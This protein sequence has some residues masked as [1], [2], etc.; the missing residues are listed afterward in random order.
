MKAGTHGFVRRVVRTRKLEAAAL[1]SG[2]A[3]EFAKTYV[4]GSTVDE[5][6]ALARR[7][8]SQGLLVSLSYLPLGEDS[9][10]VDMLTRV[11]EALGPTAHGAELS[12]KPSTIGSS[13]DGA[14]TPGRLKALCDAASERGA[15]VTLEMEGVTHFAE[16]LDLWRVVIAAHPTLGLTLPA[17]V[18]RCEREV[19]P[20][21][22]SGARLRVCVG[23]HPVPRALGYRTEH[24][25]DLAWVRLL[26]RAMENG[27]YAM[28][29]THHPTL[30][31][32]A[33]DLARRCD[34]DP[35]GFEF[36]MFHGVRPLEQRRLADIGY[37]S[38][39]YIPFGP[40]WFEYL[41]SRIV[42]R[43]RTLVGYLRA[44]RD[45]R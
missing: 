27:A 28:V 39:T 32:I 1:T 12:V 17:N 19:L 38:R 20:L 29:A 3:E 9:H 14:S 4:A 18:R 37:Q 22:R 21:A 45:K 10:T 11:L 25:R 23:A 7:L 36:Q 15:H 42:A 2:A 40:G 30:I 6:V 16:T 26:R 44:I 8:T 24:D 13:G 41:T 43:P 33:Q 5:A 31:A 34:I 35:E